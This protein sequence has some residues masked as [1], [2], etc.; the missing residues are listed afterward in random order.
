MIQNNWLDLIK[1]EKVIV[2]KEDTNKNMA[3]LVAEPL[4]KGFGLTLGTALRRVLLS[5][6]QGT[7]EVDVKI[8]GVLHEF[9]SIPGVKED[10]IDLILNI[11]QIVLKSESDHP[12]KM[13]LKAQGA[14]VVTAG[15]IETSSE[16]EI[17]NKDFVI[18]HLDS[19]ANLNIEFFVENGKG[20]RTA[21]ENKKPDMPIG[22]IPVD[23]IFSPVLN[24]ASNVE[25]ARVGQKTDYDKLIMTIKTNGAVKPEDAL[26]LAGRILIDQLGLFVNFE[27]PE[28]V[29]KEEVEEELPFNKILLKKVDELELSVRANNCLKND[30]IV[31][32]G[33]L[34]QKTENDML[35]TP[36]FGRKSLNEIKEQLGLMG[37]YLGMDVQGWPPENI[38]ELSKKFENPYK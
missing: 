9:G 4:E 14:Q 1:P 29:Q 12:K 28:I 27:D 37:L 20:Y 25:Q 8:D 31:Y 13:T 19:T 22:Y 17:I 3:V 24:V 34:V 35:K 18:C 38:E 32:I 33:E 5:S 6:L 16:T 21:E 36:N 7:T 30:N 26:A 10:V 11:K 23:S 15:M 2:E